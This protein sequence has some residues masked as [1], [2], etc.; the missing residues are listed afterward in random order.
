MKSEID[1]QFDRMLEEWEASHRGTTVNES[2]WFEESKTDRVW[3]AEAP[4]ALTYDDGKEPLSRLPW[5]GID[6]MSRVQAYGNSKYNDFENYRK[7]LEVSR[8]LSCA[9][10]HIRDFMNGEDMDRE[11]GESHLGHAMCRLAF[12]LQN[13]HDNVAI[14]DRYTKRP[15]TLKER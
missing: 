10:R 12:V 8:N 14:D 9:I 4:K 3:A 15:N 5:A 13:I 2:D 11:S 6:S 1:E 7:G